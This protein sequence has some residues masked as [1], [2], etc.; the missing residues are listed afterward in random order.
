[1]E[2][3]AIIND[4]SRLIGTCYLELVLFSSILFYSITYISDCML[5]LMIK[6]QVLTDFA[7]GSNEL[8]EN[9]SVKHWYMYALSHNEFISYR[10]R[11]TSIK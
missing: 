7:L 8:F 11:E 10:N 4:T 2:S 1:M 9:K 3:I 5:L 6:P